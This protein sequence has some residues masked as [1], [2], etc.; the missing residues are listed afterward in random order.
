MNQYR[1]QCPSVEE[2]QQYFS[3]EISDKRAKIIAEHVEDCIS[4]TDILESL[5]EA[6]T[7]EDEICEKILQDVYLDQNFE[8][9]RMPESLVAAL[10]TRKSL[11]A[12]VMK[13]IKMWVGAFTNAV[14]SI[15][16]GMKELW[17]KPMI[18]VFLP[19]TVTIA[20][21]LLF[22]LPKFLFQPSEYADLAII[23]KA[24]YQAITFKGDIELTTSQQLFADGMKFYSQKKY[25]AAIQQL[26][27]F[28]ENEPDNAYGNFYLGVSY[29]LAN[30]VENGIKSLKAASEFSQELTNKLLLEQCY[31]YLGN[32]YLENN[33]VEQ[34]LIEF[35]NVINRDGEFKHDA[36]QQ[37][38]KIEK[39]KE[40]KARD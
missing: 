17:Q 28:L 15:F 35:N 20:I 16:S 11:L 19:I 1:K 8:E 22:L 31:W 14:G 24:P 30:D 37:I 27:T 32:A 26:T 13:S 7:A 39:M 36:E 9:A 33:N 10:K 5:E 38:K 4:C 6:A 12:R 3:R 2:L 18:K 21:A 25:Q 23:K 40:K 34:A 29:L